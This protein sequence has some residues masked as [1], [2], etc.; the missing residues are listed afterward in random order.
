M[1]I[2]L[3]V[4]FFTFNDPLLSVQFLCQKLCLTV[5]WYIKQDIQILYFMEVILS[6]V[7]Q[8][9]RLSLVLV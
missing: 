1:G 8:I 2:V 3:D 9:Q 6:H 5:K 4:L 7:K